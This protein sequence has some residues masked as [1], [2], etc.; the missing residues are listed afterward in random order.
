MKAF[1]IRENCII[2][3]TEPVKAQVGM[4][5]PQRLNRLRKNS[6]NLTIVFGLNI[7]L[8]LLKAFIIDSFHA[9]G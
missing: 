2:A 7:V 3:G 1:K 6:K 5:C 8:G 9:E 4:G